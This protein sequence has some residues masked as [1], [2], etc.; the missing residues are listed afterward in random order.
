M[1]VR[2][3]LMWVVIAVVLLGVFAFMNNSATPRGATEI[4]Y[5]ELMHQVDAGNVTKVDTQGEVITA[6]TKTGASTIT[7]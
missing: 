6:T 4:S 3:I 1:P 5:S 7:Y 2:S